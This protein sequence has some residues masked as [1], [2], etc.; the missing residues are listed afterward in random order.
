R[1]TSRAFDL[2]FDLTPFAVR[3]KIFRRVT[4][5]ILVPELER[6]ELEDLVHFNVGVRIERFA[7][8]HAAD[9]VKECLSLQTDLACG[10]ISALNSDGI[11]DD[12]GFLEQ[13]AHLAKIVTRCVVPAVADNQDRLLLVR[14]AHYL[15]NAEIDSVVK[16]SVLLWFDESEL[17]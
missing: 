7:A 13:A 12:V 16:R 1:Q 5:R 14:A 2:N 15:F 10:V 11:S 17:S 4:D 3:Y 8:G 6:D 9:L